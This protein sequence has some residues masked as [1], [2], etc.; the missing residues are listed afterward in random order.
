M[1]DLD[2]ILE[3][4]VKDGRVDLSHRGYKQFDTGIFSLATTLS[5]VDLSHNSIDVIPEEI[6]S[7]I[8]L[9]EVCVFVEQVTR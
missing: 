8:C 1:E 4:G 5:A 6:S 3:T 2:D 9:S 7:L